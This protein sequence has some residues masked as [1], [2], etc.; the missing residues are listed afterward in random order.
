MRTDLVARINEA[1]K[2]TLAVPE[3]RM[4][5]LNAGLEPDTGTPEKLAEY[6]KMD[7]ERLGK[8]I[9][10]AGIKVDY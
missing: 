4:R 10:D 8:I 5:M 1:V 6:L 3:T 7:L 2:K 9:R